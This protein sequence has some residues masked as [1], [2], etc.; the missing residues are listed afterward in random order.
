MLLHPPQV[1]QRLIAQGNRDLSFF[2]MLFA[3]TVLC[4]L[5]ADLEDM[6]R[7][8]ETGRIVSGALILGPATGLALFLSMAGIG[9]G[10]GRLPGLQ[11]MASGPRLDFALFLGCL[12]KATWVFIPMGALTGLAMLALDATGFGGT[13]EGNP[14]DGFWLA[15]KLGFPGLFIYLWLQLLRAA[16]D[17]GWG[18]AAAVG[19]VSMGLS[20]GTVLFLV[21]FLTGIQLT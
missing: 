20:A 6:G 4:L 16:F 8:Y 5:W 19:L 17:M 21:S 3:G 14:G 7:H 11:V 2:S 10:V 18:R 12:S 1:F 15:L 9:F 13:Q